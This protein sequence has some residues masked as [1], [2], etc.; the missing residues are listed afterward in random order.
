MDRSF[1]WLWLAAGSANLG[2]G[3][4]LVLFPLLALAGGAS[5]GE[6][7]VV[8]MASTIAWPLFGLHAGW[9]VDRISR[10][11][12][13]AWVN[14]ARAAV[15]AL[16]A[17]AVWRDDARL[18]LIVAAA[19]THGLAETLIDTALTSTVPMLVPREG[20][21]RANARIEA[22]V[23]L[24]N[25]LAGPPLAGQ[26]VAVGYALATGAAATLYALAGAVAALIALRPAPRERVAAPA[27]GRVRAGLAF[28]WGHPTLRSIT[29]ITAAMNL[30]WGAWGAVFVIHATA[31]DGLGLTP[32]RYGA[33]LT[34]M[35]LG[36]LAASALVERARRLV[37]VPA[38]LLIDCVGTVLLVGP[39]ALGA[40]LWAVA[41]GI[42]VAGAGSSVWRILV[43][44]IRQDLTPDHLLGRVYAASRVISW[45][46]APL[47][48]A[49]AGVVGERWGIEAV[50]RL[51]TALAIGVVAWFAAAAARGLVAEAAP[52][53]AASD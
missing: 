27:H 25:Q 3:M 15:M 4:A 20:R 17:A 14:L 16:L 35:A 24:T 38:L 46:A 40:P 12:I 2:D 53:R 30:V 37:G 10:R 19:A 11:A 48:A 49:L 50:F 18:A 28:L 7:A 34:A 39:A 51:A 8:A 31:D 1:R 42:V 26:L 29:L 41:T 21:G 47:G 52:A 22:T 6:V 45:G 9:L 32:A 23:N 5:P 36:G 44:T 33:L 43:A 13:L